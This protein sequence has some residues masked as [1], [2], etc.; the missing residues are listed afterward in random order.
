M[1]LELRDRTAVVTG[2]GVEIGREIARVLAAE[3][4]SALVVARE[5]RRRRDRIP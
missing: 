5:L 3:G 1:D 2:C 4:G